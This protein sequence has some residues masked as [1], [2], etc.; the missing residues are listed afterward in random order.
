MPAWVGAAAAVTVR[1]CVLGVLF[2]VPSQHSLRASRRVTGGSLEGNFLPELMAVNSPQDQ[3]S[4]CRG[5][6]AKKCMQPDKVFVGRRCVEDSLSH[7]LGVCRAA[8]LSTPAHNKH[9]P[10]QQRRCDANDGLI[11][12][13][14]KDQRVTPRALILKSGLLFAL[15][16]CAHHAD[17]L[18][19]PGHL[20]CRE[21]KKQKR[22]RKTQRLKT[23]RV[24][25]GARWCS[26]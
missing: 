9:A 21:W 10:T 23:C 7:A 2:S 5:A 20:Y 18:I 3:I 14:Q 19:I 15:P 24:H 25:G 13:A 12:G 1:D 11:M 22:R 4:K 26:Y 8:Q 17:H 16:S 6:S